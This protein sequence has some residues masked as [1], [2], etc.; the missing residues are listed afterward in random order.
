LIIRKDAI[1]VSYSEE[2]AN[3]IIENHTLFDEMY[4][5]DLEQKSYIEFYLEVHKEYEK[6]GESDCLTI[7]PSEDAFENLLKSY[8]HFK[9]IEKE[10]NK[11]GEVEEKQNI[12]KLNESA[13]LHDKMYR[14]GKFTE[15][16]NDLTSKTNAKLLFEVYK[17]PFNLDSFFVD[18]REG[19]K[20]IMNS[21]I[22]MLQKS[23]S[24]HDKIRYVNL[25]LT[26]ESFEN[27]LKN[28]LELSL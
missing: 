24:D 5:K 17:D 2:Y 15:Y 25:E 28:C 22:N 1:N 12:D 6:R 21:L 10:Q 9:K 23:L 20:E 26:K 8:A 11:V 18:P 14:C 7:Q 16:L 13:T 4:H 3:A 27:L 19:F